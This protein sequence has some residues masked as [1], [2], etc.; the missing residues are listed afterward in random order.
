MLNY[1]SQNVNTIQLEIESKDSEKSTVKC[2]LIIDGKKIEVMMKANDFQELIQQRFL[3]KNAQGTFVSD[4]FNNV[5]TI[6]A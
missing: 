2:N 6:T 5:T 1:Q 4:S 3:S